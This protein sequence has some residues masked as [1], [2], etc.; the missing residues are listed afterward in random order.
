MLSFLLLLL[1]AGALSPLWIRK[2]ENRVF[3]ARIFEWFILSGGILV[4]S[5]VIWT[6]LSDYLVGRT[7]SRML[8]TLAS[9]SHHRSRHRQQYAL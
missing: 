3:Y 6:I 1:F 2:G 7:E 9:F 5:V 8:I 4:V